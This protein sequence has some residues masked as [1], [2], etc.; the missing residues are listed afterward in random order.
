[1]NEQHR[2]RKISINIA[3]RMPV[4]IPYLIRLPSMELLFFLLLCRRAA[5]EAVIVF[6]FSHTCDILRKVK[7]NSSVLFSLYNQRSHV[8]LR[9]GRRTDPLTKLIFNLRCTKHFKKET[10]AMTLKAF[11]S[12]FGRMRN[13]LEVSRGW[14]CVVEWCTLQSAN[15]RSSE[16]VKNLRKLGKNSNARGKVYNPCKF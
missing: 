5:S 15:V 2:R 14:G 10:T 12:R 6:I 16:K 13:L 3:K 11:N 4:I 1:M 7:I 8:R 9:C